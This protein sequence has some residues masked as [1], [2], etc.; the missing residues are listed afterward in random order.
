MKIITILVIILLYSCTFDNAISNK[1]GYIITRLS[2]S[3]T[4]SY[5]IYTCNRDDVTRL[6]FSD[7]CGKYK[8]GDTIHFTK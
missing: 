7:T 8:V 5:C 6:S 2:S 4:S 1:K 3:T